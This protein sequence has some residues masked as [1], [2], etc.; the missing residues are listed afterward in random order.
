MDGSK[1]IPINVVRPYEMGVLPNRAL[2]MSESRYL[3]IGYLIRGEQEDFK[4][5]FM[6]GWLR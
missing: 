6:V 5:K 2:D 1:E 3:T 4:F